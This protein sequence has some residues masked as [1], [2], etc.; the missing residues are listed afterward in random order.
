MTRLYHVANSDRREREAGGYEEV[1]QRRKGGPGKGGGATL[2][3]SK[4]SQ[5]YTD[6]RADHL[7]LCSLQGERIGCVGGRG[8]RKGKKRRRGEMIKALSRCF[9]DWGEVPYITGAKRRG[10]PDFRA[11]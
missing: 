4:G 10:K 11:G 9:T 3:S 7:F 1:L 8:E 6:Q 2:T 5:T